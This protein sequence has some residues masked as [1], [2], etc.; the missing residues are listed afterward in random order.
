MSVVVT[1]LLIP[2]DGDP[3]GLLRVGVGGSRPPMAYRLDE[4]YHR[5]KVD[6]GKWF[7][8][9]AER[10]FAEGEALIL[11]WGGKP[12]P[13]G[14]DLLV[15]AINDEREANGL[16]RIYVGGEPHGWSVG[17]MGDLW[18]LGFDAEALGTIVRV[19]AKGLEVSS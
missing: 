9:L 18:G 16:V 14:L 12:V 2:K 17:G 15:R 1:V 4:R 7:P 19:D 13:E 3:F 10:N 11:A 5:L 8:M 6:H